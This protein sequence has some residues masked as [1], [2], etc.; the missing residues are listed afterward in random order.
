MI[1]KKRC[2]FCTAWEEGLRLEFKSARGGVPK[3]MWPTYSAFANTQ[4][5]IIM[6]GVED[7]DRISGVEN[8]SKYID[9]IV[10]Q[11]NNPQ[12]CSINLCNGDDIKAIPLEGKRALAIRVPMASPTQRPAYIRD[13]E[14]NSYIRN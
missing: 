3:E 2:A 9:E 4:G 6:L 12:K 13:K 10:N 14:E 7:D 1:W 8:T 11:L 5:G